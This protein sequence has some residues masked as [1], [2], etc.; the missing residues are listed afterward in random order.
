[1]RATDDETLLLR[2]R[3]LAPSVRAALEGRLDGLY[4]INGDMQSFDALGV[5]KQQALLI[6]VRRFQSLKLWSAVHRIENIYGTGGVGM[7]FKASARLAQALSLRNDFTTLFASRR[8]RRGGS[9][10]RGFRERRRER[11]ALHFLF[12]ER[13]DKERRWSV[14]F[15]FYNP[16]AS[17]RSAW[18]HFY[19]ESLRGTTPDWRAITTALESDG[20]A[21]T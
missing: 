3:A 14:H 18:R 21:S 4:G 1:V 9:N 6:F 16:L 7:S 15:D 12:D 17:P 10:E 19:F 11:A 8:S 13:E 20:E 5:D 2:W